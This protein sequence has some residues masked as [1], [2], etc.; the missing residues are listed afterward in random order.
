MV[1]L[2][3]VVVVVR[4]T[5]QTSAVVQTNIFSWTKST[6][7][8]AVQRGSLSQGRR[9]GETPKAHH[10]LEVQRSMSQLSPSLVVRFWADS[11]AGSVQTVHESRDEDEISYTSLLFR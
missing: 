9:K 4:A 11:A 5:S 7:K 10:A 1:V 8:L 2:V 6:F 3:V